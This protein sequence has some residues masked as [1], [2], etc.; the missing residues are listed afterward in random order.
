MKLFSFVPGRLSIIVAS[1]LWTT[2]MT[3]IVLVQEIFKTHGLFFYIFHELGQMPKISL[4][5]HPGPTGIEKFHTKTVLIL[6]VL[7]FEKCRL[8]EV[9]PFGSWE[10]YDSQQIQHF[11]RITLLLLCQNVKNA[12]SCN[13]WI[14]CF[15]RMKYGLKY[16]DDKKE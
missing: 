6:S 5:M 1:S 8:C 15:N 4:G 7:M 14:V 13:R 10:M 11:W 3:V 2:I 12:K 16:R 9:Y